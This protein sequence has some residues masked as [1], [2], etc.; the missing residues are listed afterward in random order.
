MPGIHRGAIRTGIKTVLRK[1]WKMERK[2]E[3]ARQQ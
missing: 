1:T 3:N 2:Y